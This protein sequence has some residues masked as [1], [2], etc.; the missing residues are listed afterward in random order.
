MKRFVLF[1][2]ALVATMGATAQQNPLMSPIAP[3]PEVRIGRL[4]NGMT[5]YIRHNEK[6]KEMADFWILYNVGAIQEGDDQQGLAHFLEHMAF[7][8]TKNLPGKQLIE[9]CEKIGVKFGYNLN[10]AT[11]WDQTTYR[12]TDVPV[13]KDGA[14]REGIIDSALLILHDWSHFI[15]LEGDEIDSERGVIMEELRTRDGAGWRSTMELIKALGKGTRYEHRNLIGYL[16]FLESFPYDALRNYYAKWYRPELIAF[17]VVGDV[18]VDAIE[19]KF[20]SLMAD[21][22]ASPAD[23]AQKEVIVVPDNEEPI[24]SVY[25]DPEMQQ[26]EA[27]VYYKH[28]ARPAQM[29]SLLMGEF[30]DLMDAYMITMANNR[31]EEI[32][33]Q[34]DAPF[35]SAYLHNGSVGIIPTLETAIIGVTS[36]EGEL[37]TAFASALVE[38]ERM[39][40]HGFS[41]GEFE[42]AKAELLRQ[43][44]RQYDNRNDRTNGSFIQRYMNH[45]Q[46]NSAI[47]SAEEEWQMDSV[48]LNTIQV[49]MINGY[50]KELFEPKNQV[51]TVTAPEKEGLQNPTEEDIRAILTQVAALPDEVITP[52]ADSDVTEP[53]IDPNTKFKGSP[54]KST[55]TDEKMGTIEWTLKNGTR[56]IVKPTTFKADEIQMTATA[57]GGSA[58]IPDD[59]ESNIAGKFLAP[60]RSLS[61]VAQFT[62]TDLRKH[63]AGKAVQASVF[64]SDNEHGLR[65]SSSPK[66]LETLLQLV[67]LNFTAPRFDFNDFDTFY[68]Q[69]KGY[70]ENMESN[71]DYQ[72]SKEALKTLYGGNPR[73]AIISAG[74]LDQ[75][76]FGRLSEINAMLF[77]DANE[78]V[79]TFVGNVDPEV[80]R[81]LVEKYI[82]SIPTTKA[83]LT[84]VDDHRD[85][86]KGEVTNEFRTAMQQPKVTVF[87]GFSGD[88][89]YSLKN[90]LC[91]YLLNEALSTRYHE[92]IREEMG[93]TYG[94][95]ASGTLDY[96]PRQEYFIQVGCDTNEKQADEVAEAIMA[97]LKKIA[98]EGPRAEDIEKTREYLLKEHKNNLEQNGPWMSYLKRYYETQVDYVN[99][100]DEVLN[101][102]TYDDVKALARKILEDGNIVKVIMRPEAAPAA[103]AAEAKAE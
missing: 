9:Y 90:N 71:P 33:M 40:R 60:I 32:T 36:K 57:K 43:C 8:G 79:F 70:L 67:Y 52:Y 41:E 45:Y 95:S 88:I 27:T 84:L 23:A 26:S 51:V 93:A 89:D 46:K 13:K 87:F 42:R 82:G 31:L 83:R 100:Y 58:M 39:R 77:P 68:N 3:D 15:A 47:P 35:L 11:S 101:S 48:L 81:P 65:G 10:A 16:D 59:T 61:G 4:E 50:I 12:L 78:F 30:I 103:E 98:E 22:P 74:M 20:K 44:E 86:V 62:S 21:I 18:D 73:S 28:E 99:G 29:N 19:A 34:P 94:V 80:L 63:L 102:I 96:E 75:I 76:E 54:V 64:V 66:D 5:Y 56:I 97:E 1:I 55:V 49:E 17:I 2:V 14:A 7:N 85:I 72:F 38:V 25:T 6:P 91:M 37:P 69:Y 53:L 92:T 24:I